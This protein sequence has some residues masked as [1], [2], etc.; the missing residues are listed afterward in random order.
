MDKSI[1]KERVDAL[2]SAA[3]EC[4]RAAEVLIAESIYSGAINRAYY[5]IFYTASAAL[6]SEGLEFHKHA[7][8][9]GAFGQKFVASGLVDKELHRAFTRAFELRLKADYK[10]ILSASREDAE[11]VF[12]DARKFYKEIMERMLK[13]EDPVWKLTG[14]TVSA[15]GDLSVNHDKYLYGKKEKD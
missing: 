15:D 13:P 10:S 4:L 6:L 9:L 8:V 14:R 7:A 2:L 3:E 12:Q 1:V 11:E 5:A